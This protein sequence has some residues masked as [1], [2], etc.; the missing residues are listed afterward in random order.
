MALRLPLAVMSDP[1]TRPEWQALQRHFDELAGAHLRE[2]FAADPERGQRMAVEAGDLYL[3]YSKN[4]ITDETVR[5]LVALAE[6]AGVRWRIHEM[7]TG[8]KINVTEDRA[9]LHVALRAPQ[10]APYARP[11]VFEVLDR[12]SAFADR[13]RSGQWRGA[14][15]KRIRNVVNIGIGG[16]DL[17]PVMAYEALRAYSRR[18]MTF[19]FV[20][21][22]DGTDFAEATRDL[23]PEETLFIVASRGA[24]SATCRTA[25]SSVTLIFSPENIASMRARRPRSSASRTS[26]RTVSSVILFFE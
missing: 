6:A 11:E 4:L 5:L 23:D 10:G 20:S 18:D 25:R 16:S 12:M 14:T 24:R 8:E 22:V 15:G 2:L 21:N 3:D 13:V 7:F 19:R 26:R 1:T 17:G 9:V